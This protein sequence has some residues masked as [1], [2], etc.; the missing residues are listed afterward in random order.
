MER[1]NYFNFPAF[2]A[3]LY[4][5]DLSA[6]ARLI[7]V[8]LVQYSSDKGNNQF[9]ITEPQIAEKLGLLTRE[10][11][12][13]VKTVQRSLKELEDAGY[14]QKWQKYKG[15]GVPLNININF[16]S[17]FLNTKLN[18]NKQRLMSNESVDD[19][20]CQP[21]TSVVVQP[22]L[23]NNAIHINPLQSDNNPL[24]SD[25]NPGLSDK[26]D[27]EKDIIE[28]EFSTEIPDETKTDWRELLDQYHQRVKNA[29][30]IAELDSATH[31]FTK[32]A[33]Q[34]RNLPNEFFSELDEV[35]E[36][37]EKKVYILKTKPS[38][39]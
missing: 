23:S 18:N 28:E 1:K 31:E 27:E 3:G 6:N 15:S 34:M 37:K 9:K 24:Q 30:S 32:A 36:E 14:L 20:V 29:E 4:D 39:V 17:D 11:N 12:L 21:N 35:K 25:N 33:T 16:E 38:P 22:L 10:G 19:Q 5:V 7:Y 2:R 8:H 13:A 26:V